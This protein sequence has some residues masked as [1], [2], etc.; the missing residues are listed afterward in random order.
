M[1][2]AGV[3]S[4]RKL[5]LLDQTNNQEPEKEIETLIKR[6]Q[7]HPLRDKESLCWKKSRW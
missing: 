3:W 7:L 1:K 2:G 6:Q 5:V 4:K